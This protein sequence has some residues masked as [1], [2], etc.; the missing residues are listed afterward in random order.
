[1]TDDQPDTTDE[2]VE[3]GR[4]DEPVADTAEN[5]DADA[6]A[7]DDTAEGGDADADAVA[8]DAVAADG[9]PTNGAEATGEDG[10]KKE[11][12]RD[13]AERFGETATAAA[14][15]FDQRLVDLLSWVLDTET[16]ARIF[17]HLRKSPGSTSDEVAEGTGLYPSTV[18][19]ALAELH[20]DGFVTRTKRAATGAGNNPYEYD[21]IDPSELV[22]DVVDDVQSELNTVFALDEYLSRGETDETDDPVRITVET[23][24]LKEVEDDGD[25]D[26]D[27]SN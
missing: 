14:D 24:S 4:A 21:A 13:A 5:G 27:E 7:G 17:V 12:L 22:E 11:G 16:R 18:R 6:V 9:D 8:E 19:E 25:E 20:D 2:T 15:G 3:T 10:G 1:M 26:G 23:G